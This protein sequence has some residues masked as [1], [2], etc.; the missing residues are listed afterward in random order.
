[1]KYK[2]EIFDKLQFLFKTYKF[3]DH[4]LHLVV[5]FDGKINKDILTKALILSTDII[6]IL[7]SKYVENLKEHYW[8]ETAVPKAYDIIT[9]VKTREAFNA[10]LTSEIDEAKSPQVK[11]CLLASNSDSLAICMNHM[12]CDAAGFKEYIYILCNL[13]CEL[14]KNQDYSPKP[15]DIS[16]RSIDI[17][18]RQ[19]SLRDRLKVLLFQR[20]E[21]NAFI[22]LNFPMSTKDNTEAFILNH[23]IPEAS[24]LRIKEYCKKNKV[25]INDVILAAYYRVLYKLFKKKELSIS[26]A[27]DMRKFLKDKSSSTICN[28]SSTVISNII[29]EDKDGFDDTIRKVHQDMSLK[30]H[31]I[32]GLNG[33]VKISMLFKLFSYKRLKSLLSS[34]FKNPLI[35]MTNIGILDDKK[36]RFEGAEITNAFMCGSMKYK[37]YF[38]LAV[39]T[40]KNAI[41]LTL[42]LV[43]NSEDKKNMENFF[44]LIAAELPA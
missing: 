12:V 5:D 31:N 24:F 32:I 2:S 43:G 19:F 1:M 37:P 11:A 38:Q 8:E 34:G 33:F 28:L 13:Y 35:G 26:A 10:F 21:S 17:I 39:T 7:R 41:T 16:N 40:Y 36:L 30:K 18:S 22:D 3:N 6:P 27:V 15:I 14:L 20:K 9:L 29:Y 23:T 4:V 25:T 44:K 42:N